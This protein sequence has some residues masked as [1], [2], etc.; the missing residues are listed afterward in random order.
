MYGSTF[1]KDWTA[2]T[3]SSALMAKNHAKSSTMKG[4][5]T[6]TILLINPL[7]LTCD[8]NP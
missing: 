6:V 7:Y 4:A 3:A 8:L 1:I 2:S 5:S